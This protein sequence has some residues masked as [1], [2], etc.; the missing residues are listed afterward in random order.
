MLYDSWNQEETLGAGNGYCILIDSISRRAARV[1]VGMEG[2]ESIEKLVPSVFYFHA[3]N[4]V[5]PK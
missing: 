3:E 5:R 2:I 1:G 4:R